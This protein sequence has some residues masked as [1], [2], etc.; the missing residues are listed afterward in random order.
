VPHE[1]VLIIDDDRAIAALASLW[2]RAAGYEALE[3]HDGCSGLAAAIAEHPSLIL[4]DIRMRDIDGFEVNRRLHDIPGLCDV[5]VFF[6]SAHA[7][8]SARRQALA[9]GAKRFFSKPYE[10]SE[11]LRAV[12]NTLAK[13]KPQ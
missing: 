7:Q 8:E 3:A 9:A 4:L 2:L 11:L 10:P 12:Q 1:R 6:L 13:G 5:P